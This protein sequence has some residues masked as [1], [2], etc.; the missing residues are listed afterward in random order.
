MCW[1]AAVLNC[2]AVSGAR[3]FAVNAAHSPSLMLASC[4]STS[5]GIS[6]ICQ[7]LRVFSDDALPED[8]PASDFT[9]IEV[10]GSA[11]NLPKTPAQNACRE[12]CADPSHVM[13]RFLLL[14]IVF[15]SRTRHRDLY[16]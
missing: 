6:L 9:A 8:P 11:L 7:T 13:P 16:L 5:A 3:T 12:G 1:D 2:S 14:A 4:C 10:S 15:L